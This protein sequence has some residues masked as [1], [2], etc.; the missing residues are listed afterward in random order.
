MSY[1]QAA[2]FE[3]FFSLSRLHDDLSYL[4][5]FFFVF[6]SCLKMP[7]VWKILWPAYIDWLRFFIYRIANWS[8]VDSYEQN[9]TVSAQKEFRF[10][11]DF[12]FRKVGRF[13]SETVEN[14][15]YDKISIDK[16]NKK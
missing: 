9:A 2:K 8:I 11:L 16:K 1:D 12:W 7:Y 3:T 5:L 6:L 10:F 4:L 14:E 15:D 13:I